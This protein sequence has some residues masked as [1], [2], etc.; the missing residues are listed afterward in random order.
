MGL[1]IEKQNAYNLNPL[2]AIMQVIEQN[3]STRAGTPTVTLTGR[4]SMQPV[5]RQP[6]HD[7]PTTQDICIGL[8]LYDTYVED[9]TVNL[10]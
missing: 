5:T 2:F 6:L 8:V 4:C 10:N 7:K 3:T 1:L 9:M